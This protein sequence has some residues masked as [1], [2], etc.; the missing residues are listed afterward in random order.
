LRKEKRRKR[1]QQ[2][3][4]ITIEEEGFPGAELALLAVPQVAAVRC[5]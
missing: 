3:R 1:K 4:E 5:N 2:Q